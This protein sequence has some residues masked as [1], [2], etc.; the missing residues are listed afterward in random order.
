[1]SKNYA[2]TFTVTIASPAVFS[3]T[4]HDLYEDDELELE[5]TGAL[6]TGLTAS[7]ATLREKYWVIRNGITANTFQLSTSF[8]GDAITTTGTQSG[9]H[10]FI[11]VAGDRLTPEFTHYE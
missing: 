7:T 9:T 3:C 2:T 6:P 8:R 11:K 10:T 5:T 1:M 4:E